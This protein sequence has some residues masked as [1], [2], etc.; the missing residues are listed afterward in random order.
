MMKI[1]LIF[2]ILFGAQLSYAA[3]KEYLN[4]TIKGLTCPYCVSLLVKKVGALP[5]VE[6]VRISNDNLRLLVIMQPDHASDISKINKTI[7]DA[8]YL[9]L[10]TQKTSEKVEESK[11]NND[12]FGKM[13]VN[14]QNKPCGS[15]H[16]K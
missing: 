13:H 15:C 5:G 12:V 10:S 11:T 6:E 1:V 16:N 8:G 14:I 9:T 7:S 4:I 3:E 2:L